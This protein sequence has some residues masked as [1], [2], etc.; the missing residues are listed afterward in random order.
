MPGQS[1]SGETTATSAATATTTTTDINA[2]QAMSTTMIETTTVNKL[3]VSKATTGQTTT[4]IDLIYS[5]TTSLRTTTTVVSQE[6]GVKKEDW[7]FPPLLDIFG[8]VVAAV[9]KVFMC[10]SICFCCISQT[11]TYKRW[12]TTTMTRIALN[13]L[14]D[15]QIRDAIRY[16]NF[17]ASETVSVEHNLEENNPEVSLLIIQILTTEALKLFACRA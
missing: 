4:L 1:Q 12:K 6:P 11:K 15:Q 16:D 14:E 9:V 3:I 13:I 5:N 8:V 17:S 2:I 10:F 7:A